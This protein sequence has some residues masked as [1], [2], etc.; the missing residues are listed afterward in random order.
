LLDSQQMAFNKQ[1]EGQ[2]MSILVE[3]AGGREGQM[4][5]R[6]PFM[7]SVYFE[8]E[9]SQIGDILTMKITEG[10]QNSLAAD[11]LKAV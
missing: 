8:G 9:D 6:S 10:R 1:C 5:G 11:I 2:T 4:T 3:R 7:Q